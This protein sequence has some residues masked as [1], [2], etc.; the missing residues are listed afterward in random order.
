MNYVIYVGENCHDCFK[1]S[2]TVVELGLDIPMKNI[3]KGEN[4]PIDLFILPALFSEDGDLKAYG[5]DIVNF[6]KDPKNEAKKRSFLK[7]IF[8]GF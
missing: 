4:P 6:L 8:G 1:V 7:R 2:K 5:L 3:D